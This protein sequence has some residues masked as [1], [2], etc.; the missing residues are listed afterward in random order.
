MKVRSHSVCI[1]GVNV[2]GLEGPLLKVVPNP[3]PGVF[4]VTL[5]SDFDEET[6]FLATNIVGEKISEFSGNTNEPI[7]IRLDVPNGVYFLSAGTIHG[8]WTEK[9]MVMK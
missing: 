9:I 6:H 8:T 1:A 7:P 4:T 5:S 2:I 3:G